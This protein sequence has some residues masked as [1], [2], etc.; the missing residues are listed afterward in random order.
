MS[1]DLLILV[2]SGL[3]LPQVVP[4]EGGGGYP[5]PSPALPVFSP[6][7][8][9]VLELPSGAGGFL[10]AVQRVHRLGSVGG[11]VDPVLSEVIKYIL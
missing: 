9:R 1:S 11:T 6:L 2:N 3:I 8:R 4:V 5:G 10:A 7:S